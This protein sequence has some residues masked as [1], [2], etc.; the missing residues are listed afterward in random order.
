MKKWEYVG[1]IEE[2]SPKA[3]EQRIKEVMAYEIEEK[4]VTMP[5]V[6]GEAEVVEYRCSELTA[7]CPM[8][9]IRDFYEIVI[10]FIPNKLLPELKS[11]KR[12][13]SGYDS[14]PISHEHLAAKIYKEFKAVVKPKKLQLV[15]DTSVRGGIKTV[16]RLGDNL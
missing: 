13:F 12:Y 15:L 3:L 4:I 8:T 16:I 5:Y 1:A 9:G 6:G 2:M 14:L 11:L 7:K 10:K